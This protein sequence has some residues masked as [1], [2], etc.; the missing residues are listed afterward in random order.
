MTF[1]VLKSPAQQ[2]WAGM[3]ECSTLQLHDYSAADHQMAMLTRS[4]VGSCDYEEA[5]SV[6]ASARGPH[7]FRCEA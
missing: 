2:W 4:P 1:Q 3:G 7:C 5:G 6:D